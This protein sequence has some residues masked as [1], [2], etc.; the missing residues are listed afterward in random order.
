MKTKI[1]FLLL[2]TAFWA[3]AQ[4][5][6]GNT[7]S[8]LAQLPNAKNDT[9]RARIYIK[10]HNNLYQ[11]Q[12]IKALKYAQAGLKIVT[13]MNWSKGLAVFNNDIGNN[14]LDQGK[15][16]LALVYF[17]KSLRFS[18]QIANVKAITLQNTAVVYFKERNILLAN[19]YNNAAFK[20]AQ[21]EK[22]EATM[23]DCYN[24]FGQINAYHS[25]TAKAKAYYL[26]AYQIWQAQNNLIKQA[27]ILT[28]LGDV[29]TDLKTKI[30]YYTQSKT[31]W[32][33]ENPAY[34]LAISN[35][36]GLVDANISM[37]KNTTLLKKYGFAK[38]KNQL[39]TDA[40]SFINAA[41]KYSKQ[42][43]V[44]QNL[45]Y[46]YGKMSEV[47]ELQGNYKEALRYINLNYQIYI[48]IFS[49]ERKNKIAQV[50]SQKVLDLKN[51]A[52]QINTIQLNT[53]EK[54]KWYLIAGL[55]L[56]SVIIT[57]LFYQS[58]NRRKTNNKLQTLNQSLDEKV[59]ELNQA[60][61]TKTQFFN[62][63]N[64]DLR[65]PV[66]NLIDFLYIQKNSPDLLDASTKARIQETTLNA[67][68]NLLISMEDILLWSKNQ[69]QNFA[70]QPKNVFISAIFNH[71]SKHF[72]SESKTKIVFE[73]PQ[74]LTLFT[75]ENY[76]KTII[77]NLTANAI[78]ALFAIQ[79]PSI[80]WQAYKTQTHFF[81]TIT[82]NGPGLKQ[83]NLKALY[84]DKQV[85]G[86]QTGLGLHLI[87]DLA[88]AINCQI[89]VESTLTG[90]KFVLVFEL[91]DT[92]H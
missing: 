89:K 13:K 8:L 33:K 27:V 20:I 67:A 66:A 38:N 23:A 14:Y 2:T 71:T 76:L 47:K 80:T 29:A 18:E 6:I 43:N 92:I 15:H 87:R 22:L 16:Q 48:S 30:N 58:K 54:Q 5:Q 70:P 1:L 85:V 60:N 45:M 82:D 26:K 72:I 86:I 62:I 25:N 56:L 83:Q 77:R 4:T 34:V 78:K 36:F 12:P 37:A 39:L 55:A 57:L 63:L 81:L 91:P 35:L 50:Q 53:K 31:I 9:I 65:S 90:T 79:N 69:M 11:T 28:L 51:K 17:L 61:K 40:Q 88:L 46:A 68:E 75:D 3:N 44:Q 21:K 49:Q 74:N 73:N 24:I 41:I 52:L 32:D 10:L 84:D 59:T 7:D 64:H 42:T 19:Q